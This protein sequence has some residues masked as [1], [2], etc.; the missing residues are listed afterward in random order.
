MVQE[1]QGLP[2]SPPPSPPPAARETV[3]IVEDEP[4]LLALCRVSLKTFGYQVL[5]AP[6]PREALRLA[7][8]HGDVIHLL[9]TDVVLPG[10]N[11]AELARQMRALRPDIKSLFMSG[12]SAEYLAKLGV[13]AEG[14]CFLRKPFS[15][16][17]LAERVRAVIDR[18]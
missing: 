13:I 12:H 10:M 7:E 8:E 14:L 3:L 1:P 15:R 11:G 2:T 9:L 6:S 18:G 17:S 5:A 4:S 16:E